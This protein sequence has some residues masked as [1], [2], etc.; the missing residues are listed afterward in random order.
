MCNLFHLLIFVEII[1]HEFDVGTK[2][3][4]LSIKNDN[5]TS[6]DNL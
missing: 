5:S 6:I 3:F 2:P 1:T 4:F